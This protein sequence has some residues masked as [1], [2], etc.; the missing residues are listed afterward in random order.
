MVDKHEWYFDD[1]VE[2]SC[3]NF[4]NCGFTLEKVVSV[5]YWD[6]VDPIVSLLFDTYQRYV[7]SGV[8]GSVLTSVQ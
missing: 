3:I 8:S 2:H 5:V 1:K 6:R 4:N 7:G